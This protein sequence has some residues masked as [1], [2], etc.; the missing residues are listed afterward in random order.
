MK[1]DNTMKYSYEIY[2]RNVFHRPF[3]PSHEHLHRTMHARTSLPLSLIV[4]PSVCC[5]LQIPNRVASRRAI[6]RVASFLRCCARSAP[7]LLPPQRSATGRPTAA[8]QGWRHLGRVVSV[9]FSSKRAWNRL[10]VNQPTLKAVRH[11]SARPNCLACATAG[12][13]ATACPHA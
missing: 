5:L 1:D 12:V 8:L 3:Q 7:A 6:F 13:I 2:A 10:G 4:S 11:Y 9:L